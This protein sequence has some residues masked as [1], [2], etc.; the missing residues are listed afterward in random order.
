MHSRPARLTL[1][2]LGWIALGAAAFFIVHAQQQ[3]EQRRASL[4]AFEASAHDTAEALGDVQSGQQ[5]YV[6]PGQQAS[7]W[8]A[9]VNAALQTANTGIESLRA[10]AAS[11]DAGP[12]LLEANTALTQLKNVDRQA[13]ERIANG[14]LHAAADLIFTDAAD[15]VAGATSNI[16]AAVAAEQQA[17]SA[18]EASKR[19]VQQ[20]SALAGAG[21]AS[22]MLLLLGLA[23][24]RSRAEGGDESETRTEQ[25]DDT[26]HVVPDVV[27]VSPH[28]GSAKVE[29]PAALE[30]IAE[31]CVGA[32]RARDAADLSPLLA[33]AADVLKARGIIVWLGS[34]GGADLRP[35]LAHGYTER[36][37]SRIPTLAR[38]AD[39][40]VA[41]AYRLGELQIVESRPGG[42]QG[43]IVAPL[44]APDGC[45]GAVTAEVRDAGEQSPINRALTQILAAQLAGLLAAAATA[46]ETPGSQV[47]AG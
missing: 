7:E 30:R 21:A 6:A 25:R 36:T 32:G 14:E 28:A 11:Q 1:S 19:Q 12:A 45:I 5:A 33:Q 24:P 46:A 40:A 9:K 3:T 31:I 42:S 17:T 35:V 22:V 2:A 37:L 10:S 23:R 39:N 15:A 38:G 26:L 27:A 29:S 20:A 41:T 43:T 44:L 8:T 18:L 34:T 16:D 47:A 13:R 4:Q